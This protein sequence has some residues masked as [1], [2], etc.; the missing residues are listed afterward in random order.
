MEIQL[1]YLLI[2]ILTVLQSIIGV[3]ILVLG[4]PLLLIFNYEF[5]EIMA[6]LLPISILTS[7][8]NY[9]YLKYHKKSLQINLDRNIKKNFIILFIPGIVIGLILT[10]EFQNFINF[11]LLVSFVIILSLITKWKLKDIINV[12]PLFFKR[13][14]LMLVGIIHGLTNSGGTLLTI[15]FTSL[16]NSKKDQSRYSITFYY[17]IIFEKAIFQG[18]FLQII[19]I[20]I[21]ASLMGNM[22]AKKISEKFFHR[23]IEILALISA[24]FLITTI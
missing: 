3:G 1:F 2:F 18:F 22:V 17:L 9:L 5:I 4:T 7:L 21:T 24:I 11:K 13:F 16:N 19:L 6:L 15:F 20:I 12:S 8:F 10:R 23:T 14:V